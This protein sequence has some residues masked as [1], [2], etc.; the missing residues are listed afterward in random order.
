[1]K[2]ETYEASA[3][4]SI[5]ICCSCIIQPTNN[6][7]DEAYEC[8]AYI[9]DHTTTEIISRERPDQYSE[10]IN[11]AEREEILAFYIHSEGIAYGI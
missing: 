9:D 1:M 6:E 8:L 11:A 7:E 3:R 2:R 4:C 10:E 5:A